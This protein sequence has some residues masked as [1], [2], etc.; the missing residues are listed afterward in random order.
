MRHH[1][2]VRAVWIWDTTTLTE[3]HGY[4]TPPHGQ[5]CMDIR[6]HHT[7]RAG[8]ETPQHWQSCMDMRHH[9]TDRAAW[10]LDTTTL[11]ELD[12]RHHN[13][14]RAGFDTPQHWQS[15]M[16]MRHHN[17]YRAGYETPLHWQ[18]WIWNITTMTELDTRHHHT[19]LH[20]YE[21]PPHGQSC[22][23]WETTILRVQWEQLYRTYF[24][25]LTKLSGILPWREQPKCFACNCSPWN[26]AA[27]HQVWLQKV[28][29]F[30]RVSVQS[31]THR[32]T[33]WFQY[34]PLPPTLLWGVHNTNWC[35]SCHWHYH[36]FQ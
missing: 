15:C 20:G 31:Q 4:K 18:S 7:D 14:D 30:R 2:T 33:W 17:T 32:Q 13:T 29:W 1:Y 28:E 8:F 23:Y 6:H 34:T 26:D 16:D 21:T 3:L 19:E 24:P 22:M 10:I 9:Y 5:S 36:Q 12:L 27:Q 25:R 35:L 11:T